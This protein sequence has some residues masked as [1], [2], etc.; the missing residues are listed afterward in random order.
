MLWAPLSCSVECS[1]HR[2]ERDIAESSGWTRG[3][4]ST[5]WSSGGAAEVEGLGEV[6]LAE[7]VAVVDPV[8]L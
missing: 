3:V 4:N 7:A 8:L 2:L 1:P 5:T 6:L